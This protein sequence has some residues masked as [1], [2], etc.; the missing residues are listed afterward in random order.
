MRRPVAPQAVRD[1]V[2]P[3]QAGGIL[4]GAINIA[5]RYKMFVRLE[6]KAGIWLLGCQR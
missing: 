1:M 2:N 5:S 3:S 6:G 4:Q